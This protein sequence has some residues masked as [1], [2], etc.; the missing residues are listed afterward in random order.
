VGD[1]SEI[2]SIGIIGTGKL[3]RQLLRAFAGTRMEVKQVIGKTAAKAAAYANEFQIQSFSDTVTSIDPSLD[4]IFIATQDQA[5]ETIAASLAA[6]VGPQTIV[7]HSSGS[8]PLSVLGALGSRTGVIYPMQTFTAG[9][10]V[11]FSTVPVFIE[12]EK[13]AEAIVN[14]VA[15]FLSSR[16]FTLNSAERQRLHLGAVFACNFPN[17]MWILTSK[18]ASELPGVDLNVYEHL[19]RE[20]MQNVFSMGAEESLTGP[21]LRGDQETIERHLSMLESHPEMKK[22]Y[23]L[24]SEVIQGLKG[25]S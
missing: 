11:D 22:I 25:A 15:H 20:N 5:I 9:H 7:V 24:L 10:V 4:L 6:F 23:A 18:L 13:E 19:V 16:V 3:S 2:K 12:F 17:L 8:A 21:A 14:E 1:S